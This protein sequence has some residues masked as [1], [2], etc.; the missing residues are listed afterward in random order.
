MEL[1]TADHAARKSARLSVAIVSLLL[2]AGS[3]QA[4][5]FLDEHFETYADQAAFQAAWPV[6]GTASTL[7]NTDQSVSATHS[8]EGL[9]T[10]TR[11]GRS[12]G[13][14][15]FLNGTTD[16]VV[17]KFHFYDSPGSTP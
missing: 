17:F 10:A 7:L 2:W 1:N 9:T 14:I 15:G 5:V 11:N 4:Q 16:L 8:V 13:Q 12:V 6:S 3:A